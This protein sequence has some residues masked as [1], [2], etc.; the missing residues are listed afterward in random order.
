MAEVLVPYAF[1]VVYPVDILVIGGGIAG[2]SV[3]HYL[4][5]AGREVLLAE[6][7]PRL[8]YHTT[9]R[10]AAVLYESYGTR[11]I[12]TLTAASLGFLKK[13][14]AGLV[15]A[16]LLRP[17]GVVVVARP[18]QMDRLE[19][20]ASHGVGLRMISP[21]EVGAMVSVIRTELL[22]GALVEPQAADLDVAALHQAFV[23]GMRRA[24]GTIRLAAPVEAL[25][26]SAG[27]WMVRAG[28][29]VITADVV[30]NAAG[31][32]C[33]VVAGIAGVEPV[34]LV[35]MRR[36]AFMVPGRCEWSG[37]PAVV[38]IDQEWY[39]R[40][41]GEQLLCS[42]GEEKPSPPCD[43]RP[44]EIDIAL[45]I[46]RINR[47]T[48]LGIRTVRSSWTGLRSFVSDRSMVIG[49]DGSVEGFFWLAGQGGT[50]IQTAP[51]AGRLAAALITEGTPPTDQLDLGVD[52]EAFSPARLR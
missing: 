1:P 20:E 35:A 33:D 15:D 3:C 42:L 48:T 16:P 24:G 7:E 29:E 22:A 43:A 6:G 8:A 41:D 38:D 51:G 34:G 28:G 11:A 46:D 37:W 21:S 14:P 4:A 31:A 12:Q 52:V 40:P 17:R 2:V 30:V 23:R 27:R 5:E 13:P 9:G 50:G 32:W 45:A 49:F 10:S 25:V 18:D 36:T 26:R 39:F 44:E 19:T 47:A